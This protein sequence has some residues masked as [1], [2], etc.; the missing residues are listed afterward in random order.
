MAFG[1]GGRWQQTERPAED[2]A[3]PIL[4]DPSFRDAMQGGGKWKRFV[5]VEETSEGVVVSA[6]TLLLRL[7]NT[8]LG[9]GHQYRYNT[10]HLRHIQKVQSADTNHS[11]PFKLFCN[12]VV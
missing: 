7:W 8:L 11:E 6:D 5:R 1:V 10:D 9:K 12:H 4:F 2:G 3:L